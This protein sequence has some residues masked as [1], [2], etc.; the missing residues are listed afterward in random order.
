MTSFMLIKALRKEYEKKMIPWLYSF[1]VFIIFRVFAFLFF[2]IVNDL[3][4]AYNVMICLLW[5]VFISFSI[6]GWLV[7]YSLF[8]ELRDLTKLEDLAHLRVSWFH[9]FLKLNLH[10]RT[11]IIFRLV[12]CNLWMHPLL[13]PLLVH[14]RLRHI[15]RYRQCQWIE[16]D[17]T[18]GVSQFILRWAKQMFYFLFI[19][20]PKYGCLSQ[21]KNEL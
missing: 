7:V 18:S 11:Y 12:L 19:N 10:H 14:D 9:L 5:I 15:V 4:F 3:I 16:F 1:A 6:Y 8:I 2:S 21:H 20:C 17:R 13:I